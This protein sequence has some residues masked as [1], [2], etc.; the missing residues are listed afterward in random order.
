MILKLRSRIVGALLFIFVLAATLGLY[1]YYITRSVNRMQYDIYMLT[2]LSDTTNELV[3][4]HHIWRYN[5][6]WAFLYERPFTGGLNP[7]TC[8]Y[9]RWLEGPMP[10]MV[11]DAQV[12]ALIAAIYQPH[13]D[14]HV[15]GGV[16]LAL[17]NEGRIEEA[18]DLLYR[19]V[20]P[21]GV[22]STIRINALRDRYV[23]LRNQY[24]EVL[25]NFIVRANTTIL[26]IG[27]V[28]TLIFILLSFLLTKSI[29][30]PIR[31]VEHVAKALS[32]MDF[33]IE[34]HKTEHDEIGDIQSEMISIRDSLKKGI[35]DMRVA[36][37]HDMRLL[38]QEKAAFMERTHAILDASPMVCAIFDENGDII[39]VNKSREYVWN[40]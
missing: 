5:L 16:A 30:I 9:G 29:L 7:H 18:L 27:V 38:D 19:V 8:I 4:A 32:E 12:R 17:R 36:H 37:E 24:I 35:E 28:A 31:G 6:A 10:H 1:G 22:E 25:D 40:F 14:L 26:I 20:F 33:D 23:E 21:A 3:E 34:I 13:Y 2:E 11:D 39:D 15:Q